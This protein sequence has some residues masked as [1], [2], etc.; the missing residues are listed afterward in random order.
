MKKELQLIALIC[1]IL[2][3]AGCTSQTDEKKEVN[4]MKNNTKKN[5]TMNSVT[6]QETTVGQVG[7]YSVGV[8][9]IYQDS[10]DKK[11]RAT[12]AFFRDEPKEEKTFRAMQGETVKIGNLTVIVDQIEIETNGDS[13]VVL[14]WK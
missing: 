14:R 5:E 1:V 12:L 13:W 8:G 2:L 3:F 6:V 4:D 7:P 9:N 11:V 10:S